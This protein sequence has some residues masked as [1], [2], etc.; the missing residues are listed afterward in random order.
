MNNFFI[1]YLFIPRAPLRFTLGYRALAP[2]ELLP[3]PGLL[4]EDVFKNY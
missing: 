3:L 4:K 1:D 2:T